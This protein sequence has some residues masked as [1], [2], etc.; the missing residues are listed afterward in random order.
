MKPKGKSRTVKLEVGKHY[1]RRDGKIVGPIVCTESGGSHHFR[2]EGRP[3]TYNA[4]GRWMD[5]SF[6]CVDDLVREVPA[7]K[8]KRHKAPKGD[9]RK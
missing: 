8:P 9:Q 1:A 7:P 5:E 6:N 2:P 4:A 3:E